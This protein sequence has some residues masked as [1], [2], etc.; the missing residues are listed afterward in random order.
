MKSMKIKLMAAMLAVLMASVPVAVIAEH[1]DSLEEPMVQQEVQESAPEAPASDPV[2][3]SVAPPDVEEAP[4]EPEPVVVVESEVMVSDEEAAEPA[5]TE[6]IVEDAAPAEAGIEEAEP[7]A[8]EALADE[9]APVVEEAPAAKTEAAEPAAEQPIAEE[10]PVV[11]E[12]I[13][14]FT[15]RVELLRVGDGAIRVGEE[16]TL[17]AGV[18]DANKAYIVRIEENING[19]WVIVADRAEYTFNA[20]S[21]SEFRAVALD[22]QGL[23]G[24]ASKAFKLSDVK[25]V[26]K[27]APIEDEAPANE[28]VPAEAEIIVEDAESVEED[29][30]TEAIPAEEEIP[31]V[32]EAPAEPAPVDGNVL[33]EERQAVEEI[34]PSVDGLADDGLIEIEPYETPLGGAPEVYAMTSEETEAV[35][36]EEL[37]T[38]AEEKSE[39][40]VTN[41]EASVRVAAN[42][43]SEIFAT[44]PKGAVL[45]VLA[46]EGDWVMV[47]L[48]DETGYIYKDEIAGIDFAALQP[49]SADPAGDPAANM[50]VTIFSSRRTVMKAGET[51]VLTSKLE[52][53]DGFEIKY[54]WECDK[55]EGFQPV[56]DGNADAYA[57]E[58]SQETLS[59]DWRL[60]VFYR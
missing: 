3:A 23:Q 27:E 6:A 37:D 1:G 10:A 12:A 49:E 9:A 32:E 26:V 60:T 34:V 21:D 11:E 55:G 20:V 18:A 35:E 44:L 48:G 14:P 15:C 52:G 46:I 47:R 51:V 41:T 30:E 29:T 42:G 7:A 58:A 39:P 56:A 16:V 28:E 43:L 53:F 8:E 57:F 24:I 50:K 17:R 38:V 54:Q 59:W 40:I 36:P 45:T 31:E 4:A 25:P 33:V 5:G 22:D 19:E 13:V 2:E